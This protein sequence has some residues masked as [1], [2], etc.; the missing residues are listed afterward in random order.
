MN[1]ANKLTDITQKVVVA[2]A[3]G[4]LGRAR[5]NYPPMASYHEGWAII[6]E[7]VEEL[8]AEVRKRPGARDR[9]KMQE[10]AVQVAAMALRFVVDLV[11]PLLSE[12]T[13]ANEDNR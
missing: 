3:V 13:K 7:E 2:M 9:R 6:Q 4:E 12:R 1:E 10:E 11:P 5:A 8:W